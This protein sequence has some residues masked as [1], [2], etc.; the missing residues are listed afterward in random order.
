MK[1]ERESDINELEEEV[2]EVDE[3]EVDKE[4]ADENGLEMEDD[5]GDVEM[6]NGN[7]QENGDNDDDDDDGGDD[8]EMKEK[9]HAQKE[10]EKRKMTERL[11]DRFIRTM[12]QTFIQSYSHGRISRDR[13]RNYY[14]EAIQSISHEQIKE[15]LFKVKAWNTFFYLVRQSLEFKD[16]AETQEEPEE[17]QQ[18]QQQQQ[19][20]KTETGHKKSKGVPATSKISY[21]T[22]KTIDNLIRLN[23]IGA[24][25][26][27][28]E[29]ID[30]NN[31][32]TNKKNNNNK[33]NN[34]YEQIILSD[35]QTSL[36]TLIFNH[37][38][39]HQSTSNTVELLSNLNN[40]TI[41]SN[42][43]YHT[44][45]ISNITELISNID[46]KNIK[47]VEQSYEQLKKYISSAV[48]PNI[49]KCEEKSYESKFVLLATELLKL[50]LALSAQNSKRSYQI[51]YTI[52]NM[53][54]GKTKFLGKLTSILTSFDFGVAPFLVNQKDGIISKLIT[55]FMDTSD[56]TP[57]NTAISYIKSRIL[58]EKTIQLF[59]ITKDSML[60]KLKIASASLLPPLVLIQYINKHKDL[61]FTKTTSSLSNNDIVKALRSSK[62]DTILKIEEHM[63]NNEEGIE[64][65]SDDDE[66]D[67]DELDITIN[68]TG[69]NKDDNNSDDEEDEDNEDKKPSEE[70]SKLLESL[71][72]GLSD[73][74]EEEEDDE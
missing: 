12:S 8:K 29:I 13:L 32:S 60:L 5:D 69:N 15:L 39:K 34:L 2:E 3:E 73:E 52:I 49:I 17:L 1:R 46:Y 28:E 11:A 68:K 63:N 47:L 66:Q 57:P 4:E 21:D 20:E 6:E 27:L 62:M 38:I 70:S 72:D 35:Q 9:Q 7:E 40:L 53:M 71:L 65:P 43:I 67:D 18:Q 56:L 30:N 50:S 58:L 45:Y 25:E 24:E 14:F 61:L 48:L 22:V 42:K 36:T 51:D 19:S 31:N 44:N 59:N 54:L 23:C 26:S 10:K 16:D 74:E 55:K 37:H 41:S 64:E 33:T